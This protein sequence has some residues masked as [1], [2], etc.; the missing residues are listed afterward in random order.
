MVLRSSRWRPP[1][2]GQS[3]SFYL[4]QARLLF[5]GGKFIGHGYD[6]PLHENEFEYF[7]PV[8][9]E[10][11][12]RAP[13]EVSIKTVRSA[14]RIGRAAEKYSCMSEFREF[15]D[16]SV[17]QFA[18]DTTVFEIGQ[19]RKYHNLASFAVAEAVADYI[20]ID[21]ANLTRQRTGPD[22]FRPAFRG[23]TH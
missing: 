12:G 15:L 23:D 14:F 6:L 1:V 22:V 21:G 20:S 19:H 8:L 13:A 4:R 3:A 5:F 16:R 9:V 10:G 2:L 17:Q 18:T 7:V 11:F